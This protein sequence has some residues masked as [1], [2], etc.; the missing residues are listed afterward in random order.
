MAPFAIAMI[1]G[2]A[3]FV[4]I[5]IGLLA[6]ARPPR[7][8]ERLMHDAERDAR[9]STAGIAHLDDQ[10]RADLWPGLSERLEGTRL[11][12]DLQLLMLRA[13]LLIRPSEAAGI[14]AIAAVMGIVIVWFTTGNGLLALLGGALAVTALY[15]YLTVL[16]DRR[17]AQLTG[18]LPNAL[19]MLSSGLRSGHS[20]TRTF[21][22]VVTQSGSP[23]S[24]EIRHVMEDINVGLS[25]SEALELLVNRT[26]SY[27][28]E[29]VVAA[30]Q[31]Q[32]KLGGN[33]AEVLDNIAGVIRERM[34]LQREIDAAT[35]EGRLSATILVAMPF[36]MALVISVISPGYL[37]PLFQEAV[38]RILLMGAGL[39]MIIGIIVIKNLIEIDF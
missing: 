12:K 38:G 19:D 20:L 37:D 25:T 16:A 10:A 22:I 32:L 24:D 15:L 34:T 8:S 13:G 18:Q 6:F 33:L 28:I 4:V 2:A 5:T 1:G 31:I 39:L 27:D 11:W 9:R 3:T 14:G 23:M 17:Q 26:K 21:R 36:V 29:L 7:A 35:S 30:I